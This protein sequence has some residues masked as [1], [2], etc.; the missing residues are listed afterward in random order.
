MTVKGNMLSYRLTQPAKSALCI[1]LRPA[2]KPINYIHSEEQLWHLNRECLLIVCS[3]SLRYGGESCDGGFIIVFVNQKGDF[4]PCFFSSLSL[5]E[6][7]RLKTARNQTR[8]STNVWLRTA[9]GRATRPPPISTCEVRDVLQVPPLSKQHPQQCFTPLFWPC[10]SFV[11]TS[12]RVELCLTF[13]SQDKPKVVVQI[14]PETKHSLLC[15]EFIATEAKVNMH[16]S[17]SICCESEKTKR[18]K[19]RWVP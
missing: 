15:F 10:C 12:T 5:Q 6:L 14:M 7:C 19:Q 13:R 18:V 16:I 11:L 2:F 8:A 4:Y 1:C 17:R 3:E 9:P